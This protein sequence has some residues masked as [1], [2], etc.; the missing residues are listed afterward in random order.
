VFDSGERYAKAEAAVKAAWSLLLF[1]LD[2]GATGAKETPR[3]ATVQNVV[4]LGTS[5]LRVKRVKNEFGMREFS[6]S[7]SRS[8]EK[9]RSKPT[10]DRRQA[11]RHDRSNDY[12]RIC[13]G[14]DDARRECS[15][16]FA[17]LLHANLN[18]AHVSKRWLN[19]Q[20]HRLRAMRA[21]RNLS[22]FC[23]WRL[24]QRRRTNLL[25]IFCCDLFAHM[26]A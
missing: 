22:I 19:S 10:S 17:H 7:S 5:F 2:P 12:E 20:Q 21:N 8:R 6:S 16:V 13:H 1:G 25:E 23:I 9:I 14:G 24:G 4:G 11:Q 15:G 26:N 18:S 3:F